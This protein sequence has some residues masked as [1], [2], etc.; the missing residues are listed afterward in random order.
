MITIKELNKKVQSLALNG[1]KIPHGI[2]NPVIRRE[3]DKYYVAYF[4][5]VYDRKN[6][7]TKQYPRPSEWILLDVA[8]GDMVEINEC[9][10]KDF[11]EQDM[12]KL[13]SLVDPKVKKPDANYFAVMDNLFDTVRASVV[14]G[15]Q[16]DMASYKAYFTKLL[17]IT[18]AEYQVFYKDLTI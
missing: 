2:S 10:E 18:P 5:Y 3:N 15:K 13:Y 1:A 6:L 17:A 12:S 16:L 7:A 14:F 11:S 8:T 9:V 4:V